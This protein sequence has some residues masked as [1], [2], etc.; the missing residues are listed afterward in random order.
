MSI[1]DNIVVNLAK[2]VIKKFVPVQ[3]KPNSLGFWQIKRL[4]HLPNH[5]LHSI[6]VYNANFYFEKPYEFIHSYDELIVDELYRFNAA[7]D[8]PLIIDCGANIGLSVLYFKH[9]YPQSRIIAFE[10]D[11]VNNRLLTKNID[12]FGLQNVSLEEKAIWIHNNTITF[13][14]SGS[15]GSKIDEVGGHNGSITVQCQ[16][17][18]DLL[19][20]KVDFL[21][22]DIEGAEY[23]VIKD[24]KHLLPNVD[25]LFVEYHGDINEAYKLTEM[26]VI[27]QEAGFDYYLQEAADNVQHPLV[28]GKQTTTFDQQLNIFAYK[29]Q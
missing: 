11:K 5:V 8:S 4:K 29:K 19:Q 9:L 23:E 28:R 15:Q 16:R 26:L 21:K 3:R 14:A 10:P 1:K 18:A 25:H 12:S 13:A 22:I 6:P 24:C 17:L 20:Q 2:G 27:F 7:T